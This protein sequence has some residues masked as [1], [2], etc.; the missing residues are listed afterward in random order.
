MTPTRPPHVSDCHGATV[1][2]AGH[3]S[4]HWWECSQCG[5][6]CDVVDLGDYDRWHAGETIDPLSAADRVG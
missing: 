1:R 6:P 4:T 5:R 3:G 2:V